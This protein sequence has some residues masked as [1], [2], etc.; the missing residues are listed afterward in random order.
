VA[1]RP[2]AYPASPRCSRHAAQPRGH[3]T[4]V[5]TLLGV[6]PGTL[7]NH[8]PDLRQL[9]TSG[10]ARQQLRAAGNDVSAD[11]PL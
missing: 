10:R 8:L 7:Y 9:R 1:C 6:S 11:P 2:S 4:R 3:I 5:A